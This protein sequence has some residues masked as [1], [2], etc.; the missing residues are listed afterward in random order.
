[1]QFV[2]ALRS[3]VNSRQGEYYL[4]FI[5]QCGYT[6][7]GIAMKGSDAA[8]NPVLG[9]RFSFPL[10]LANP[11]R[12]FNIKE[13]DNGCEEIGN[14]FGHRSIAHGCC[15]RRGERPARGHD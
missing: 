7:R 9:H 15:S 1:M 14:Y 4:G 6:L 12:V 8:G 10:I 5:V 11:H 3:R 13:A 2:A